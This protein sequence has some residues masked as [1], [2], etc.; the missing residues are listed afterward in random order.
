MSAHKNRRDALGS[1]LRSAALAGLSPLATDSGPKAPVLPAGAAE[2]F[3]AFDAA[4]VFPWLPREQVARIGPLGYLRLAVHIDTAGTIDFAAEPAHRRDVLPRRDAQPEPQSEQPA[5]GGVLRT[6]LLADV[7]CCTRCE[8]CR[9]T[10]I[11]QP[12]E[13]GNDELEVECLGDPD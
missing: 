6:F 11:L 7:H 3:P 8:S 12:G 13:A 5:T 9:L 1:M 2:Y 10:A 4:S